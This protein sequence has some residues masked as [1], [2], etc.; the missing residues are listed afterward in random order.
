MKIFLS[1]NMNG[2]SEEEIIRTRDYWKDTIKNRFGPDTEFIDNYTHPDAPENAPRLW[3]LGR[4][5]QQM[6]EADAVFF[7]PG[8]SSANGC[9]IEKKVCKT[10][11][12]KILST[13]DLYN[14]D[15]HEEKSE[16]KLKLSL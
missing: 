1:H 6:S 8:M 11:G 13:Y 16:R 3:H 4:S 14:V 7:F 5:I 2:V 12:I 15:K 10:Y 9:T